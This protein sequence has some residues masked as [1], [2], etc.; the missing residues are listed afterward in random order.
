ML[1]REWDGGRQGHRVRPQGKSMG[2][3]REKDTNCPILST[4]TQNSGPC[5]PLMVVCIIQRQDE[6]ISAASD[7][8]WIFFL[9]QRAER[10]IL[11][12]TDYVTQNSGL[13]TP[14]SAR[15]RLQGKYCS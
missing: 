8:T 4:E 13:I 10:G 7:A 12:S 1:E 9:T 5:S 6:S 2:S 11:W 14:P 3:H 15:V